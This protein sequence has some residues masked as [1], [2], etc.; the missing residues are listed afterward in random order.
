MS[1]EID[2]LKN[3]RL[4]PWTSIW[5]HPRGVALWLKNNRPL[6]GV[7]VIIV[8]MILTQYLAATVSVSGTEPAASEHQV[9]AVA[10]AI[11]FVVDAIIFPLLFV[12]F[13]YRIAHHYAG[14]A[15]LHNVFSVIVWSQLPVVIVMILLFIS[16]LMD[17]RV[18]EPVLAN[19][20]S[21]ERGLVTLTPPNPIINTAA[22][23]WML[24]ST[25]FYLWSFQILLSGLGAVEKLSLKRII[26]VITLAAIALM[27]AR[28]PITIILND[29]SLLELLGLSEFIEMAQP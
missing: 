10:A 15:S 7:V 28:I 26:W 25:V 13:I 11:G 16:R 20:I 24:V 27:I 22:T 18:D 4:N 29:R 17:L 21:W 12:Y 1:S 14:D 23:A 2:P 3:P 9:G 6:Y 8:S 5:F 19:K